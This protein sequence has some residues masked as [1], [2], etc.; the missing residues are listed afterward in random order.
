M[1]MLVTA[2]R[3]LLN[4]DDFV[5]RVVVRVV[6]ELG[7]RAGVAQLW[8]LAVVQRWDGDVPWG[9]EASIAL[10]VVV[11]WPAGLDGLEHFWTAGCGMGD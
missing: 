5:A 9:G 6:V 11:P 2:G 10:L 3:E 8:M 1:E 7:L 4:A